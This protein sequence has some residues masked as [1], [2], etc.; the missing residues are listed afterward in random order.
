MSAPSIINFLS[1]GSSE[2]WA[3]V[4]YSYH[5]I[6]NTSSGPQTYR[7]HNASGGIQGNGIQYN[8]SIDFQSNKYV[9]TDV[10]SGSPS[11]FTVGDGSVP[12][13]TPTTTTVDLVNSTDYLYIY[14]STNSVNHYS[15]LDLSGPVSSGGGPSTLGVFVPDAKIVNYGGITGLRFEQRGYPAASY[16]L[17]GPSSNSTWTLTSQS[18]NLQ[19]HISNLSSGTYYLWQDSVLVAT[20]I[21]SARKKVFCNFW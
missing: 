14:Q 6:T 21:A 19:H 12:S 16:E 17:I 2:D 18:N 11:H 9:C 4:G 1:D 3:A 10:G 13:S 7:L 5:N 20:L 15:I 8:I